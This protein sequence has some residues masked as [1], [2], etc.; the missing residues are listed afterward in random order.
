MS[1]PG[2]A[3]LQLLSLPRLAAVG[4]TSLAVL[5]PL[6]PVLQPDYIYEYNFFSDSPQDVSLHIEDINLQ[7]VMTVSICD[8]DVIKLDFVIYLE[9]GEAG[10]HGG[11]LEPLL[12]PGELS[13]RVSNK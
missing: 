4:N 7:R 12:S 1:A 10:G 8:S 2:P 11:E 9:A 6:Y 5:S 13:S 3:D